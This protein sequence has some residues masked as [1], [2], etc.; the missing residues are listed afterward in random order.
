MGAWGAGL[1]QDDDAADLRDEWLDEY[2]RTTSAAEA[3]A[4]VRK[5]FKS[6]FNDSDMGPVMTL[7]LATVLWRHGVLDAKSKR[8]AIAVIDKGKGLDLWRE[9]GERALRGRQKVYAKIRAGLQ[10]K[11]PPVKKYAKTP[12]LKPDHPDLVLGDIFTVAAPEGGVAYYRV[13]GRSR[14]KW[15]DRVSVHLLNIKP[16][17]PV[18]PAT[19]GDVPGVPMRQLGYYNTWVPRMQLSG[20]RKREH[21]RKGVIKQTGFSKALSRMRAKHTGKKPITTGSYEWSLLPGL[22]SVSFD[23]SKFKGPSEMQKFYLSLSAAEIAERAGEI[24][25]SLRRMRCDCGDTCVPPNCMMKED[26]EFARAEAVYNIA[27]RMFPDDYSAW[28]HLGSA[29]WYLGNRSGAEEAWAKAR[30]VGSPD[31]Q[32]WIESAIEETRAGRELRLRKK[33]P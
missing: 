20:W 19:L 15:R 27:V 23:K 28:R 13:V 22:A 6:D 7:A 3:T 4:K 21:D 26:G 18:D 31:D 10:E 30:A 8:E 9:Q 29:R 16:G 5:A 12:A 2:K 32:K 11:Q 24:E 17:K 1:F 33:T 14:T 25:A